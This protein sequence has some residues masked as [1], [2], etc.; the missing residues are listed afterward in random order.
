MN[1]RVSFNARPENGL[2]ILGQIAF[3]KRDINYSIRDAFR[4]ALRMNPT[5]AVKL[6][7]PNYAQNGYYYNAVN[8]PMAAIAHIE[9]L[10]RGSQIKQGTCVLNIVWTKNQ[11]IFSSFNLRDKESTRAMNIKEESVSTARR[12]KAKIHFSQI[13]IEMGHEFAKR[14]R[15]VHISQKTGLG[16]LPGTSKNKNKKPDLAYS[17]TVTLISPI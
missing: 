11:K 16:F 14:I 12:S 3:T 17:R 2:K 15:K 9:S 8:N 4:K 1:G 6:Y 7:E 5:A 13:N 10:E